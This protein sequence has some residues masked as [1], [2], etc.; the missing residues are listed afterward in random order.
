MKKRKI[1]LILVD[2]RSLHNVGSIFRSADAFAAAKIYL[3]GIT[4]TPSTLH[5]DKISKVALGAE[6]YIDWEYVKNPIRQLA[7]IIKKLKNEGYQVVALEQS[8]KSRVLGKIELKN[9]VALVLGNELKGL[10]KNILKNCDI[11][12]E[13]PMFGKKESLNVA[14]AGG[15][16]LYVLRNKA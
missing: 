13:I 1:V 12:L 8:K 16:A 10:N 3:C 2:V 15:I 14:V 4:G 6:N 7:D 5:G 11:I 9:K